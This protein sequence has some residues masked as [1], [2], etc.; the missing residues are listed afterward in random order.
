MVNFRPMLL[1]ALLWIIPLFV[2]GQQTFTGNIINNNQDP[3]AGASVVIKG[4]SS[5]T[6]SDASGKFELIGTGDSLLVSYRLRL[7]K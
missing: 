3:I 5:G 1:H 4:T 6:I 7:T 2:H